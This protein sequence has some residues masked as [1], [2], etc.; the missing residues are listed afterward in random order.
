MDWE[1][2]RNLSVT[3]ANY[4][5]EICLI[6]IRVLFWSAICYRVEFFYIQILVIYWGFRFRHG[7]IILSR[8]WCVLQ[9]SCLYMYNSPQ[10]SSTED[11]VVLRGYNVVANVKNLNRT[12]FPFRLE[13]NVSKLNFSPRA[14][15]TSLYSATEQKLL[16][17]SFCI[18]P[19]RP[20]PR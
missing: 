11:A 8:L 4:L 13:R 16:I 6:R 9:D 10:S 12:R 17:H 20:F 2:L 18:P 5:W 3:V 7:G 15:Y 19:I 14:G 1:V